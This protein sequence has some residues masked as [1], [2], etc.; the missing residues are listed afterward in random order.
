MGEDVKDHNS[1]FTRTLLLILTFIIWF[2]LG[3]F[4]LIYLGVWLHYSHAFHELIQK[5]IISFILFIFIMLPLIYFFGAQFRSKTSL[6]L[7]KISILRLVLPGIIIIQSILF[8]SVY[9]LLQGPYLWLVDDK[10][11]LDGLNKVI[12]MTIVYGFVI[13]PIAIITFA[14]LGM[15]NKWVLSLNK[16]NQI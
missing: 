1:K 2:P 9:E 5:W 4:T 7:K 10:H 11:I 3:I 13:M 8:V 16:I 12:A 15:Y 14:G 6:N